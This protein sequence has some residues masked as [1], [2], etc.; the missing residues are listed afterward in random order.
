MTVMAVVLGALTLA[1]VFPCVAA[2]VLVRQPESRFFGFYL[3]AQRVMICP[4]WYR[5]YMS[6][7][8]LLIAAG[9]IV[10]RPLREISALQAFLSA[11]LAYIAYRI[12]VKK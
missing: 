9:V 12:V 11:A 8:L 3:E 5:W 2:V 1:F 10:E 4:R 6:A 7:L